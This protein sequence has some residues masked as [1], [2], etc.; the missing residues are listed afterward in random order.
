MPYVGLGQSDDGKTALD[1]GI[2]VEVFI[3]LSN[4]LNFSYTTMVP[5]DGEWGVPK[6]D[7]KWSG[8]VG[9]LHEE[10]VD[11]GMLLV[12]HMLNQSINHNLSSN[13]GC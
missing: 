10:R 13:S 3:E 2:F 9:Q 8:I 6:D 11:F 1:R 4:L 12:N 7:G 5:S